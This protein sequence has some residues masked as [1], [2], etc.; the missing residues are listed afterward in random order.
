MGSPDSLYARLWGLNL[1]LCRI[2]FVLLAGDA[3]PKVIQINEYNMFGEYITVIKI[4]SWVSH[5]SSRMV[6]RIK[7]RIGNSSVLTLLWRV[8][9]A[10]SEACSLRTTFSDS[11][12]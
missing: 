12:A 10:A 11:G 6:E 3:I 2:V 4:P 8:I 9:H 5:L 7:L 1:F